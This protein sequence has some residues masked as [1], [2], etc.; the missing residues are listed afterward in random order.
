MTR[1]AL[2]TPRLNIRRW[3]GGCDLPAEQLGIEIAGSGAVGVQSNTGSSGRL[4]TAGVGRLELGGLNTYTGLTTI[5]AGRTRVTNAGALGPNVISGVSVSSGASLELGPI[6]LTDKPL[7]LAGNSYASFY[8]NG[9]WQETDTF[10]PF[11][12]H[13]LKR[14]LEIR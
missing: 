5:G 6:T 3:A 4:T 12:P 9:S 14:L 2:R 8:S 11:L 13:R 10:G 1:D 7:T